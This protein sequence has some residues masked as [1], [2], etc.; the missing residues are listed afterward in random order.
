MT[1]CYLSFLTAGAR[2]GSLVVWSLPVCIEIT[3]ITIIP[4]TQPPRYCHIRK[5]PYILFLSS[6]NY[7]VYPA[8]LSFLLLTLRQNQKQSSSYRLPCLNLLPA[9]S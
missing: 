5:L 3:N 8:S 4:H 1:V 2:F 6:T 7:P 9:Q